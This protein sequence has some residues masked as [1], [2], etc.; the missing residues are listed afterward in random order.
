VE[1]G[2]ACHKGK[3][4]EFFL[5]KTIHECCLVVIIVT[6]IEIWIMNWKEIEILC[7]ICNEKI[8][9]ALSYEHCRFV[10]NY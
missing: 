10:G 2:G 9:Y 5:K 3:K 7:L 6:C 4:L 8:G 1:G